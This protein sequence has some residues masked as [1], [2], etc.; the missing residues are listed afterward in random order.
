MKGARAIVPANP[1][2]RES[3]D[4]NLQSVYSL[5][6]LLWLQVAVHTLN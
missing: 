5:V 1:C 3:V 2:A 4:G 6:Q